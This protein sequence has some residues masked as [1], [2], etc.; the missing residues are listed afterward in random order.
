MPY[1]DIDKKVK[2]KALQTWNNISN[3]NI[4]TFITPWSTSLHRNRCWEVIL[5]RLRL[6]HTRLTHGYLMENGRP[7]MCS[8][9]N[10][11]IIVEHI[12]ISSTRYKTK[13]EVVFKDHYNNGSE[14]TKKS[15]LQESNI[16]SVNAIMRFLTEVD[17]IRKDLISFFFNVWFLCKVVVS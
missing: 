10:T 15:I 6:G 3:R 8:V 14:P 11:T 5:A 1:K 7:P 9:C 16:F 4:K 13:R 17:F 12:L 2:A